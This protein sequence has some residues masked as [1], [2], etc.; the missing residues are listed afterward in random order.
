MRET[1][2]FINTADIVV[3]GRTVVYRADAYSEEDAW[4]MFARYAKS[5][6]GLTSGSV[7]YVR[8]HF[9]DSIM[10]VRPDELVTLMPRFPDESVTWE[11]LSPAQQQEALKTGQYPYRAGAPRD[12][13]RRP[14]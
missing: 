5:N 7:D 8:R 6:F 1:Y 14:A 11:E 13:G 4:K 12:P 2:L 3:H 9:G 10:L